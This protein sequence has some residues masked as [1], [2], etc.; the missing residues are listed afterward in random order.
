MTAPSIPNRHRDRLAE[1]ILDRLQRD[2][3]NVNDLD[4][5]RFLDYLLEA[6]FDNELSLETAY[7]ECDLSPKTFVRTFK[8]HIGAAPRQYYQKL[9]V[10]VGMKLVEETSLTFDVI[11]ELIGMGSGS[12]FSN[13]FL[14]AT[15]ERPADYRA[16]WTNS[17]AQEKLFNAGLARKIR[18]GLLTPKEL[19]IV[20]ARLRAQHSGIGKRQLEYDGSVPNKISRAHLEQLNAERLWLDIEGL[21]ESE[22]IACIRKALH[23]KTLRFLKLCV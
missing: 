10:E 20:I 21:K 8:A 18:D 2:R 16:R 15:G 7:R 4:V 14:K 13:A 6:L 12:T 3:E 17:D 1:A 22:Q 11:A 23:I 9:R 5:Q 19:Q